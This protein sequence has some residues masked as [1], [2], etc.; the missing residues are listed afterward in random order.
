MKTWSQKLIEELTTNAGNPQWRR[1]GGVP[2]TFAVARWGLVT[3]RM[4]ELVLN[5]G[6]PHGSSTAMAQITI[7]AGGNRLEVFAELSDAPVGEKAGGE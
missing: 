4:V 7:G 2:D 3:T 1:F 6:E 5:A